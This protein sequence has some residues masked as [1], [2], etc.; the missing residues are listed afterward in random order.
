[1]EAVCR[2]AMDATR[3][4][5]APDNPS[6]LRTLVRATDKTA[7]DVTM[8]T[9]VTKEVSNSPRAC[10]KISKRGDDFRAHTESVPVNNSYDHDGMTR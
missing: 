5:T 9:T 3:W 2:A 10:A 1:M 7:S 8:E 6:M 4:S